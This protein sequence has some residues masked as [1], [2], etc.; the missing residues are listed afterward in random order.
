M[1]A[2]CFPLLPK[3]SSEAPTYPYK[4]F[5]FL[6]FF[7][8]VVVPTFFFWGRRSLVSF[9]AQCKYHKYLDVERNRTSTSNSFTSEEE[10]R[11]TSRFSCESKSSFM[12][13]LLRP[14][15]MKNN[16]QKLLPKVSAT[17]DTTTE[18][19]TQHSNSRVLRRRVVV[20]AN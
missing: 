10:L 20:S 7:L 4:R 1:V 13:V 14:C 17:L 6:F 16:K 12:N 15:P 8:I 19:A 9:L 2:G 11:F 5:S 3:M 18:S